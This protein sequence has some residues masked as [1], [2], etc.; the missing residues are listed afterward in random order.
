MKIEEI[1]KKIIEELKNSNQ[2]NFDENSDELKY[3]KD[4]NS[5]D[6]IDDT[7]KKEYENLQKLEENS[8]N[9]KEH[10]EKDLVNILSQEE[11]LLKIKERILVLFE[12]LN[13]FD[14][15]DI[16]ARVELSLKFMEFLLA[17]IDKRI[18]DIQK[19]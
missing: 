7:E 6:F 18:S 19:Q 5:K 3:K 13:S 14:K 4:E 12:G 11:F 2:L 17:N 10:E 16:E 9:L 1:T 15:G 8:E